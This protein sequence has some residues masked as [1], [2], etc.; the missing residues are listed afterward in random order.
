MNIYQ[1]LFDLIH[2]Y[3]FGME[4]LTANTDLV[5]TLVATTGCLFVIAI[6]FIITWKVIRI[7]ANI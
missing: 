5:C 7:I 2:E 4:E 6:P 3:I 1:N